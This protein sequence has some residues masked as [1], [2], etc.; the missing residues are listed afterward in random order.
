M[1]VAGASQ[2]SSKLNHQRNIKDEIL[3]LETKASLQ[4]DVTL[5][6]HE[7]HTREKTRWGRIGFG[8]WTPASGVW[9]L[10]SREER[11]RDWLEEEKIGRDLL[12][13]I[14]DQKEI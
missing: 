6:Y 12:R 3:N 13:A 2:K 9:L 1:E 7:S 10:G 8:R 5:I 4:S 11:K 14:L